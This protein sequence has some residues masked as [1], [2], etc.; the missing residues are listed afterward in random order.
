MQINTPMRFHL[1][2]TRILRLRKQMIRTAGE[3]VG[4]RNLSSL[5]AG[6]Q[7]RNAILEI[8]KENCGR[9]GGN[10]VRAR[11]TVSLARFC[12]LGMSNAIPVKSYQVHRATKMDMTGWIG[13]LTP[14]KEK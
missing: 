8:S 11:E 12:L 14:H 4:E 5:L 2:S 1:T 10:I 13:A 6:M 9:R 7:I 3:V